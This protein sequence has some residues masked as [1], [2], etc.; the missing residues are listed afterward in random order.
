LT[1]DP[2]AQYAKRSTFVIGPDGK[3]EQVIEKANPKSDPEEL[4]KTM[5]G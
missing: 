2:K 5:P 3:L 1:T 4:L